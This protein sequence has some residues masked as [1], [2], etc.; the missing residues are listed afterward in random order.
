MYYANAGLFSEQVLALA[1]N[2]QP[3]LTCLALDAAAIDD[4]DFTAAATLRAVHGKLAQQNVTFAVVDLSNS[5]WNEFDR[6]RLTEFIGHENFYSAI[7]DQLSA[8]QRDR[9]H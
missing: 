3:K 2:A 7:S 6:Y 5:V 8:F 4:V 1:K 9:A